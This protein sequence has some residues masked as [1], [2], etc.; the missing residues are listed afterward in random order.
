VVFPEILN[1]G[2]TIKGVV[3]KKN[4]TNAKINLCRFM[5]IKIKLNNDV[6]SSNRELPYFV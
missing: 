5:A 4:A 2:K 3:A 6:K 1:W